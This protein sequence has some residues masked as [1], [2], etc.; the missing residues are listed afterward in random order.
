MRRVSGGTAV[1][2]WF[3]VLCERAVSLFL[4]VAAL[5][6]RPSSVASAWA[7]LPVPGHLPSRGG[8]GPCHCPTSSTSHLDLGPCSSP[9]PF[10]TN[11]E[12]LAGPGYE[13]QMHSAPLPWA[14]PGCILADQMSLLHLPCCHASLLSS[15]PLHGSRYGRY[16]EI[17]VLTYRF[18]KR[19]FPGFT[20][21]FT[22]NI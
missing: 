6:F 3:R 9:W 21:Q 7:A 17:I 16:C 18:K 20:L 1:Q 11:T 10:L 15:L 22:Q 19:G 12:L 8:P 13:H 2:P 4:L 5:K 14:L